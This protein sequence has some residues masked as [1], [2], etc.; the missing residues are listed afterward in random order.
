MSDPKPILV[1][2]A[3]GSIGS[4]LVK[5]LSISGQRV[6]ALV[7]NP[8]RAAALRAI[9]NVEIVPGDLSQP[10]S[11]RGCA[12]GCSLVFHCAAKLSGSDRAA[13]EAVNVDGT[14]ALVDEAARAGVKRFVHASTIAVYGFS[15]AQDITEEAPWPVTDWPYIVTKREAERRVRAAAAQIPVTIARFG[16]VVG[17]G[18]YAWTV[19]FIEKINQGLL[20]PPLDAHSGL[21]NPVYI[22]NLLDALLLLSTHPAAPGQAFNVVDGAPIRVSDYIRRLAQMAGKRPFAVPAFVFKGGALLLMWADLLRGREASATP[23]E[24]Q[25]LLHKATISN[26]KARTLL[27]WAPA[28]GLEEAFQRIEQWLRQDGYIK[29]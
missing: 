8:E 24:V 4:A 18:Q 11:L 13:F 29:A 26:E 14:Q 12:E 20:R 3:T 15:A 16:D 1:T 28:V 27:G 5:R 9:A 19:S 7:R 22:D 2:G 10:A 6:R 23:Q 17:P 25:Y 21:L